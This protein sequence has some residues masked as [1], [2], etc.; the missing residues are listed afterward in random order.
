M[1][2]EDRGSTQNPLVLFS[3]DQLNIVPCGLR[4]IKQLRF[5]L[6]TVFPELVGTKP[7]QWLVISATSRVAL[8]DGIVLGVICIRL[9]ADER[10]ISINDQKLEQPVLYR[11]YVA[12]L[13]CLAPYRRLGIGTQLLRSVIDTCAQ[14]GDVAAIYLHTQVSNEAA[15]QLYAK[16]GFTIVATHKNY[17][18]YE[19]AYLMVKH[20]I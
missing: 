5:L 17:Y 9:E 4:Q 6:C 19:D 1:G 2:D 11:C 15:V 16:S 14:R 8:Y 12:H 10:T 7:S 13:A 18:P 3:P 20:L